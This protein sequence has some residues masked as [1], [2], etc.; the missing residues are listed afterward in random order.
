MR[1]LGVIKG[2][3]MTGMAAGGMAMKLGASGASGVN[4]LSGGKIGDVASAGVNK[5]HD[6]TGNR[7][8]SGE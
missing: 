5:L 2:G 4:K 7:L 8:R 6:V 1:D 3:T